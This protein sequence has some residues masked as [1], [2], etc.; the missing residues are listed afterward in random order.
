MTEYDSD[1]EL[2]NNEDSDN[3]DNESINDEV[4]V[5][6]DEVNDVNANV[7]DD[8]DGSV[9]SDADQD[10]L[11]DIENDGEG[12][13]NGDKA[14]IV[15]EAKKKKPVI[16][17]YDDDDEDSDDDDVNYLQKFDLDVN[18]NYVSDY[19][20]ECQV[21]NFDEISKLA[22]VVRDDYNTIIDPLHRTIP[23]L[24]KYE[25]ARILGQRAKQIESGSEPFIN[26]PESVI[27]GHIIAELEL[28][29]KRIPFII[30][31]PIPDG[32]FEYWHVRDLENI[33]F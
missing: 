29:Q 7:D 2:D 16:I 23:Y 28:Q 13:G 27:D 17:N 21:P 12:E 20:P 1:I 18:T 32:S 11:S 8:D 4:D 5:D 9:M 30:R 3:S 33:S 22:V 6:V 15:V 25:R 19:H 26:I 14:K 31:R 10:D 24:T